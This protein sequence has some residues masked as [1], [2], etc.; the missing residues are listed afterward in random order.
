MKGRQLNVGSF[1]VV[2]K[3][4]VTSV[5]AVKNPP[6]VEGFP[7]SDG[8]PAQHCQH[9]AANGQM[10]AR[11]VFSHCSTVVWQMVLQNISLTSGALSMGSRGASMCRLLRY[12]RLA[13]N[14]TRH[15]IFHGAVLQERELHHCLSLV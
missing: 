6:S 8:F 13:T 7:G 11:V 5:E 3:L 15:C 2:S 4:I 9:A 14:P 10:P 12:T 1:S